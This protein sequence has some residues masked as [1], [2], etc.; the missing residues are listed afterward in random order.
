MSPIR[1]LLVDDDQLFRDGLQTILSV[2]PD[3]EIVGEAG[4]GQI[5]LQLAA[6]LLPD[7]VLM[8]VQM[9]LMDGLTATRFLKP[10]C[11]QCRVIVLTTFADNGL[12]QDAARAGAEHVLLKDVS[13]DDL[14][15]VIRHPSL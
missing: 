8:D 1:I 10:T 5:A 11:P 13:A 15:K 7:V 6:T 2:Q 9:P 4:N 3:F 12:K 14:L